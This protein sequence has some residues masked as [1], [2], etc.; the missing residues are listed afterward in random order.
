[1]GSTIQ[2]TIPALAECSA[3]QGRDF[4]RLLDYQPEEIQNLLELAQQV[5]QLKRQRKP[6]RFL[7]GRSVAL[8]FEKPSNRTR[9]SFE[10]GIFDLGA[11]PIM[12]RKEEINLGVR[13]TIA[14]TA[15]TLSRYVDGI[16]IRTFA[17]S[18]VIEL[19]NW[20]SVPVI[21]G[22]TDDHHPC[23]VMADLLTVQEHFGS[24]SG[25]KLTFIGDGNNMAHSL[26]EG[27]AL[28]G[29]DV[30]IACPSSHQPLPVILDEVRA[31]AAKRGTKVEVTE[32]VAQA[33][34][35]ASVVYTD[36]WASMGQEA[37]A[38]HR[39]EIFREFQINPHVMSRAAKD[40]IVLHCL[41]AHRGEEI[42][43]DTFE[44]H[45]NIIF[46]QAENRLHAQKAILAALIQ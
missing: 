28:V 16:M 15:R 7:E 27:C 22:L 5:K 1:M 21:N 6:H 41:P 30:T 2:D 14:D 10:V 3:L 34:E 17:Q 26:L 33:A 23:Q 44:Q 36:V 40:A 29:M 19:A 31:L 46:E 8:Y 39:R 35:G 20:A 43:A 4:L 37:E 24:L 45:A 25:R 42:E 38:A 12:L 18:D 32:N 11:H 13:E 9:V